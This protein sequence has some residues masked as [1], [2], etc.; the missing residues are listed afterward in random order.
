MRRPL[1]RSIGVITIDQKYGYLKYHVTRTN[2]TLFFGIHSIMQRRSQYDDTDN[3]MKIYGSI[4]ELF[5]TFSG[6][7]FIKQYDVS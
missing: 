2:K 3:I 4:A 5:I 7:V 6:K 1:Q